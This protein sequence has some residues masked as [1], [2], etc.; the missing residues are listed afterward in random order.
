M[1]LPDI[2]LDNRRFQDLVDEARMR[3]ARRCPEWTDHNVANPGIVL[4]ELFAWMTDMT[5]YR[6]NRL[7]YKLHVHLLEL[8][9]IELYP[10]LAASTDLRFRLAAPATE[11][12]RIP[13]A[14]CGR[15][16]ART[17]S[18]TRDRAPGR[19]VAASIPG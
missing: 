9:G 6:L 16:E 14:G 5:I 2:E 10:P 15:P 1:R 18:T 12:L 11:P 3:I 13:A 17:V 7:P 19:G 4:I 8:L